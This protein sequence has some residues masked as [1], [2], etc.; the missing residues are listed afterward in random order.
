MRKKVIKKITIIFLI[1]CCI[2][3]FIN[4]SNCVYGSPIK[5]A[6]QAGTDA[7]ASASQIVQAKQYEG[8]SGMFSAADDFIKKGQSGSQDAVISDD[9]I[10]ELSDTIYNTLLIIGVVV[11]V[12]IGLI[13]A[14]QFMTGSVSQKAKIKETLIAYIVGCVVVFG[15]FTIWAL[16]VNIIQSAPTA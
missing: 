15:A 9:S 11:A 4:L 6:I 16:V 7:T 10:K 12:I 1:M 3:P 5:D 8:I 2:F 14:I 13:I